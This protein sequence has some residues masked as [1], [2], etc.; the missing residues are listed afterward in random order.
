MKTE[1][2]P[3]VQFQKVGVPPVEVSLNWTVRGL[4]PDVWFTVKF[5]TGA[6][7]RSVTVIVVPGTV[8]F[9]PALLETLNVAVN[10]PELL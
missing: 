6:T 9:S 7:T 1:P 2:S 5:A 10:V 8:V 4:S 3:N